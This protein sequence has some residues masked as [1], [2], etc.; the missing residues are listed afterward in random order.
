M[1]DRREELFGVWT[2]KQNL[3]CVDCVEFYDVLVLIS[4]KG[5]DEMFFFFFFNINFFIVIPKFIYF[6]KKAKTKLN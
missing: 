4:G 1:S 6:F 5:K 2:L 3:R